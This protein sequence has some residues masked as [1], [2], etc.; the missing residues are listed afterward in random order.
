MRDQL[1]LHHMSVATGHRA[2]LDFIADARRLGH[3]S[4]RI[5]HGKG[6]H[7]ESGPRLRT[8]TRE[9]LRQHPQVLAFTPCKPADGG[10]GATDVLL[11]RQ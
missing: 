10:D 5:I 3:E 9:V 4:I 1:D 11:K 7:S 2:L 8:M 6:R